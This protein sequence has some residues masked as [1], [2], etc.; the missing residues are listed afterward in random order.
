MLT[1]AIP[2]MEILVVYLFIIHFE[3]VSH[4]APA[5]YGS[6][7]EEFEGIGSSC[8]CSSS[9]RICDACLYV[10]SQLVCAANED[11]CLHIFST[12]SG[13]RL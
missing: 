12:S 10:N 4:V 13:R 5:V 11:R 7:G 1:M 2:D 8:S 6:K 9:S 3:C